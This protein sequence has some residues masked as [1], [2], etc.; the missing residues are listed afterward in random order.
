ME[1]AEI[2]DYWK[3]LHA[4]PDLRCELTPDIRKSWER[5]YQFGLLSNLKGAPLASKSELDSQPNLT[6]MLDIARPIARNMLQ[7]L[8]E[9]YSILLM[10]QR[11]S[12]MEIVAPDKLITKLDAWGIRSGASLAENVAGTN[13]C[14]LGMY[15]GKPVS[16]VGYEYYCSFFIKLGSVFA[17]IIDRQKIIGGMAIVGPAATFE[18]LTLGMAVIAAKSIVSRIA[19]QRWSYLLDKSMTEGVIWLNSDNHILYMSRKC[20]SILK[21]P[22]QPTYNVPLDKIINPTKTENVYFWGILNSD[23]TVTDE[24]VTLVVNK[25][26]ISCNMTISSFESSEGIWSGKIIVIE[27]I[28]RI[29]N[30]IRNYTGN[31]ARLSF[32]DVVGSNS[33]FLSTVNKSRLSASSFSNILLLGESGTGKDVLAQSIHNESPRR[34]GPFIAINCAALPRELIASELFG[35]DEG[36]YTGAKRGGHMGKFELAQQGTIFLDEIGDMPIDLQAMLL[37][38]IEEKKVLRLGG[39]KQI[40]V[41][42]RIIAATNKNLEVEIER[43]TF[44]RD[45]YY[46]LGVIRIIIPAL[47][48][49]LDDIPELSQHFIRMLC[50]RMNSPTKSL[51]PEVLEL[52]QSYHW[53]GNVREL[54]NVLENA[55]Q[56]SSDLLITKDL[57]E[58]LLS[59][60]TLQTDLE[61]KPHQKIISEKNI[62]LSYLKSFDYN[63]SKTAK[64]LGISRKTLYVKLREY[65]IPF[66]P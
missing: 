16:V 14:T 24:S 31:R 55:V 3:R 52:F 64:A 62:I 63:K 50:K 22:N 10:S 2:K 36:A 33:D 25:E 41:N 42:V 34:A 56:W 39:N 37:R 60:L 46:R 29:H 4:N 1:N 51:S 43:N 20:H 54:Q 58:P 6:Y 32:N 15:L 18:P 44:R 59:P 57:V 7:Y 23:Q 47:R 21:Y 8:P 45:L 28:E 27:A 65:N 48:D 53:P 11:V 12:I 35:Y 9:N 49:R 61:K 17:P 13:A 40:S 30:L 19:V 5:C 38:V 66:E 26:T